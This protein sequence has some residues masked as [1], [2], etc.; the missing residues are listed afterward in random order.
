LQA[1]LDKYASFKPTSELH[2][3]WGKE[4]TETLIKDC[5]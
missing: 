3:N 1:A 5:K 2:P 4:I